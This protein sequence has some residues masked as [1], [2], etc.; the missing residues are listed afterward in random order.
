MYTYIIYIYIRIHINVYINICIYN[1]WLYIITD[2]LFCRANS[3][4]ISFFL[5][6]AFFFLVHANLNEWCWYSRFHPDASVTDAAL[7]DDGAAASHGH[8]PL[9]EH[10]RIPCCPAQHPQVRGEREFHLFKEIHTFNTR[11]PPPL[12]TCIACVECIVVCS[13]GN[14]P[15]RSCL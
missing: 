2:F 5:Y 14:T 3:F 9:R 10:P 1:S 4:C 11:I 6:F 15:G 7:L 12:D 13:V 8:H